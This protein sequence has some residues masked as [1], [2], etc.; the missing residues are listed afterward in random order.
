MP[1]TNTFGEYVGAD[2]MA[3]ISPFVTSIAMAH[4]AW[5]SVLP[6]SRSFCMR[7]ASD[8]SAARWMFAS[9]VSTTSEPLLGCTELE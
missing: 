1:P 9:S 4:P 6:I 7:F 5:Q 2:A 8:S 3:S